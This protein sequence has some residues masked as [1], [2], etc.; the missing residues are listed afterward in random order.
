MELWRSNILT[1]LTITY[2]ALSSVRAGHML[3]GYNCMLLDT[4]VRGGYNGSGGRARFNDLRGS[5]VSIGYCFL[6]FHYIKILH[7]KYCVD[8]NKFAIQTNISLHN[9]YRTNQSPWSCNTTRE[10]Q[11]T[12][13]SANWRCIHSVE[14]SYDNA[15]ERIVAVVY[16]KPYDTAH[17]TETS[18]TS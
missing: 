16:R 15:I 5:V 10:S 18:V 8:T 3:N 13:I 9:T 6:G 1:W 2:W 11:W 7:V 4:T 12:M 17:K 14:T